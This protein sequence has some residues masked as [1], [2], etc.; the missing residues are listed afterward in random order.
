MEIL[1]P[2]DANSLAMSTAGRRCPEAI[3]GKTKIWRRSF[4]VLILLLLVRFCDYL[5]HIMRS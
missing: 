3:S 1:T 4:S 2:R 5:G